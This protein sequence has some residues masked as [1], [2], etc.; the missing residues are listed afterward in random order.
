[1]TRPCTAQ[2][3]GQDLTWTERVLVVHAAAYAAMQQRGL[4]GRLARATAKLQAL[5]PPRGRGKRQVQDEVSLTVAAEAILHAHKLQGLLT[6]SYERQVE[7]QLKYV[8]RGRGGV[9]RPQQVVERGRYQITGVIRDEAA[10]SALSETFGWRAY[11]TEVAAE[12]LSLEAAVLTY[13]AAWRSERDYHRLKSAPLS[14]APLFVKRDDQVKGLVHVL[15]IAMRRLTLIACVVRRG[16]ERAQRA[17]VGLHPEH[18]Q[19][20]TARPTS[21]RLLKAFGHLSLT[22]I[23]F[24]DQV[25]RHVTPLTPLQVDILHLL[26]LS[27]DIY[28]SLARNSP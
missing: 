19:K 27:P 12:E 8:G 18:P 2:V 5:T 10:I 1:M 14:I 4:E 20:A 22:I 7:R 9:E 26:G 11:V 3:E 28:R 15:S 6:Y 21:A 17:L 23:H 24:P 16:L 25:L 13:R